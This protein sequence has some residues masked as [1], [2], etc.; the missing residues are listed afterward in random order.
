VR[1]A[2]NTVL[3]IPSCVNIGN[4]MASP[5]YYFELP[6]TRLYDVIKN[7]FKMGQVTI[8]SKGL[9]NMPNYLHNVATDPMP[10][11]LVIWGHGC[12]QVGKPSNLGTWKQPAWLSRCALVGVR[13]WGVGQRWVPCATCM[14]PIF[15]EP[16]VKPIWR[17][18]SISY[19][20]CILH[21]NITNNMPSIHNSTY[22]FRWFIR[23]IRACE[24]LITNSYHAAYWA[25]LLQR[26]VVIIEPNDLKFGGLRFPHPFAHTNDW[27]AAVAQTKLYPEALEICRDANRQFYRDVLPLLTD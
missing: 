2:R 7:G 19:H 16:P 27:E 26:R 17:Y 8:V 12:E 4:S 22:D 23:H 25:T 14:H 9:L 24:I 18:A 1:E 5:S 11:K 20:R 15:D 21:P 6:K 3:A 10:T 13:D